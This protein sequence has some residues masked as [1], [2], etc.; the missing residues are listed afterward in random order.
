MVCPFVFTGEEKQSPPFEGA[1]S[2]CEII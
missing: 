2:F 1:Y